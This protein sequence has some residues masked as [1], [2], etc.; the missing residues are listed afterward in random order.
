MIQRL[1]KDDVAADTQAR[2]SKSRKD[3]VGFTQACII[4]SI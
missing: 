3:A 1:N 2:S 4:N